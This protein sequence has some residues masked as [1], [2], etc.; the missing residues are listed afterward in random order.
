MKDDVKI[1]DSDEIATDFMSV[2][3][4]KESSDGKIRL[5]AK[6]KI[7]EVAG[8]SPDLGDAAALTFATPFNPEAKRVDTGA[9]T[10]GG[11]IQRRGGGL[12]KRRG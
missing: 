4:Y 1:P 5:V 7:R 2:P 9:K 10:K 12:K 6:D 8:L 3:D 11:L